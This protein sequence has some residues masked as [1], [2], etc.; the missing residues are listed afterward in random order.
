MKGFVFEW[1]DRLVVVWCLTSFSTVEY[2]SYIAAASVPINAF[3][4]LF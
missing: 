2:F 4:G 3:L 1:E